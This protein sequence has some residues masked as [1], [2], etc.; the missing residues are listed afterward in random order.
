MLLTSIVAPL[1]WLLY[2]S[3]LIKS[4]LS[5]NRRTESSH[6]N[7]QNA[8]AKNGYEILKSELKDYIQFQN[9]ANRIYKVHRIPLHFMKLS[10][11]IVYINSIIMIA[12]SNVS[13]EVGGDFSPES[14]DEDHFIRT[15]VESEI[16]GGMISFI[17]GMTF[18][19][20][21]FMTL[22]QTIERFECQ[23]KDVY[24][25]SDSDTD[26]PDNDGYS[27]GIFSP[28]QRAFNHFLSD[29]SFTLNE[30]ID[31]A[32][33]FS[34]PLLRRLTR[35]VEEHPLQ[36]NSNG[37]NGGNVKNESL[38]TVT[39]KQHLILVYEIGLLAVLTA[40]PLITSPLVTFKY[41]GILSP[42]FNNGI[43]DEQTM[44]LLDIVVSITQKNGT[45]FFPFFASCLLWINIIII[46]LLTLACCGI[47]VLMTT[48]A[49]DT[50]SIHRV[51]SFAY[52]FHPLYH[53]E[54]FVAS[55]ATCIISI[56]KVSSFLFNQNQ[57]CYVISKVFNEDDPC[58][59]LEARLEK[60]I[61][62]LIAHVVLVNV[63]LHVVMKDNTE[64]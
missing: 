40:V 63:Y 3:L 64:P 46:P 23:A 33:D 9:L 29:E 15:R 39:T 43:T 57:V 16:R 27:P 20:L 31:D 25:D 10:M 4:L 55:L 41:S 62:Y 8:V 21:S 28:P 12:T 26:R 17:A 61:A 44:T 13:L 19:T 49:K 42:V 11:C 52:F 50:S 22:K 60:E 36:Q 2:L 38:M 59:I 5:W 32:N 53:L 34:T 18:C 45:G 47:S 1:F 37:M 54:P 51:N 58:I 7:M 14:N 30:S 6:E 56:G 24:E 48:F 35:E